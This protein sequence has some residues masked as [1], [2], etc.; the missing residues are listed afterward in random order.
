MNISDMIEEFIKETLGSS[1]KLDISRNELANYFN[2]AP[3]QINYVLTT[4]FNYERGY[5]TES[6]RGG[7]GYVTILRTEDS[8]SD[9]TKQ[10]LTRLNKELDFRT[11]TYIIEEL[12]ERELFDSEQ[13]NIIKTAL[14][15][16]A[17]ASPFKLENRLRAQILKRIILEQK[18]KQIKE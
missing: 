7:S 1:P 2:V 6:R 16:Q 3:S 8:D 17:L 15:P 9:Y 10:I 13:A 14:S 4:R 5:I 11:A 18:R 12:E